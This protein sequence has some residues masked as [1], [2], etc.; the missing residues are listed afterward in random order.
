MLASCGEWSC[1]SRCLRA[2]KSSRPWLTA[3]CK[4]LSPCSTTRT[5]YSSF[6][7]PHALCGC[8]A[9]G[10]WNAAKDKQSDLVLTL[11]DYATLAA[12]EPVDAKQVRPDVCAAALQR[13]LNNSADEAYISLGVGASAVEKRTEEGLARRL[14]MLLATRDESHWPTRRETNRAEVL[15]VAKDEDPSL[16][17]RDALDRVIFAFRHPHPFIR[18]DAERTLIRE[19]AER[20]LDVAH[21]ALIRKWERFRQWLDEEHQAKLDL[22]ELITSYNDWRK[23]QASDSRWKWRWRGSSEL[24]SRRKL[25]Q[26]GAWAGYR[27]NAAWHKT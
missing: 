17:Q 6:S 4:G 11:D 13:T 10:R 16:A 23:A 20:T 1:P 2:S 12:P 3:W 14:F 27:R 7:M 26:H 8:G 25:E 21:E 22:K 24:L 18:E 9:A 15:A 5:T 19:D